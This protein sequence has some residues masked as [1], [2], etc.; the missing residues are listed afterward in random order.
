MIKL[1]RAVALIVGL[2]TFAYLFIHDSW[3]ADNLFLVPDLILSVTLVA[4]AAAPS[5]WARGA[6]LLGLGF[7]AGVLATSVSAY[8]VDGRLGAA[9]LAGA[10]AC[11]IAGLLLLRNNREL[12]HA[13]A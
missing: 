3:Q 1:G 8:A 2:A 13:S 4:A 6:L 5:R 9:S 10:L 7:A 11:A 12:A